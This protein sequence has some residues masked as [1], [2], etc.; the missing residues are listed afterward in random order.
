[1]A[2]KEEYHIGQPEHVN[3]VEGVIP[4]DK[5][6]RSRIEYPEGQKRGT[7]YQSIDTPLGIKWEKQRYT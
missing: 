3:L 6:Y 1:M 4:M 5:D 7:D 2:G